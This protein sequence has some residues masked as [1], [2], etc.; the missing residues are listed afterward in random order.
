MALH[1]GKMTWTELRDERVEA[2]VLPVG[3]LEQHGPH[4]PLDTDSFIAEKLSERIVKK[5]REKGVR[6]ALLPTISYGVSIE[7][8]SFPGTV[9]ISSGT[10]TALVKDIV[11][12]LC[13]NK[14][15]AL[16]VV[17]GHGGNSSTL[18][19]ALREAVADAPQWFRAA[20]FEWWRIAC[21]VVKARASSTFFH[22]DEAETS[23]ALALGQRVKAPTAGEPVPV[24]KWC[25]FDP[26]RVSLARIYSPEGV[27]AVHGAFGEP[28]RASREVGEAIVDEVVARAVE[29]LQEL[30]GRVKE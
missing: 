12:E 7:W 10:L 9:S 2:A 29:L 4:L 14:V 19:V 3:S 18:D 13:R 8:R 26:A 27:K 6:A 23:V 30:L 17:N 21:D 20:M 15:K 25:S 1:W 22:A 5:A 28:W 11:R 24:S 16:L